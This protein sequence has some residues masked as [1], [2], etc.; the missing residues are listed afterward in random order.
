MIDAIHPRYRIE[1]AW[2]YT[3]DIA[4]VY[5]VFIRVRAALM[6]CIN[7]ADRTEIVLR[8]L[9][10][11]LVEAQLVSAP[12]QFQISKWHTDRCRPAPAA[13]AAIASMGIA[14]VGMLRGDPKLDSSA[15]AGGF[16]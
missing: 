8:G 5:P 3:F 4:Q 10:V 13:K 2:I 7:S 9:R 11:P 6:M 14:K 12:D 16:H 1:I 15:M